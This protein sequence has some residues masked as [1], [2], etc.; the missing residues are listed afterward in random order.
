[1][2]LLGY[3]DHRMH[4]EERLK[5]KNC[6][7]KALDEEKERLTRYA[8]VDLHVELTL[9]CKEARRSGLIVTSLETLVG[10]AP[11]RKPSE[12]L[13]REDTKVRAIEEQGPVP[14]HYANPR[15]AR[16]PVR[17]RVLGASVGEVSSCP[18]HDQLLHRPFDMEA[19][20]LK[21]PGDLLLVRSRAIRECHA[22]GLAPS[23]DKEG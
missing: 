12:A 1:M 15:K 19:R 23:L 6:L 2:L 17:H 16:A 8:E 18:T 4:V 20:V 5:K 7:I 22:L 13:E 21:I 10:P 9:V 11:S 3:R 14:Y